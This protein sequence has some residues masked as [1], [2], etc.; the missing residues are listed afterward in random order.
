VSASST[1]GSDT[2]GALLGIGR[3]PAEG[4]MDGAQVEADAR[5]IDAKKHGGSTLG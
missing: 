5:Q 1:R 3:P 2:R 4:C